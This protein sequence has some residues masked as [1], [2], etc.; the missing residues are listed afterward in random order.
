MILNTVAVYEWFRYSE[1]SKRPLV[2]EIPS[3]VLG[4]VKRF[5]ERT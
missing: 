4:S 3:R 1:T 5:A 2:V